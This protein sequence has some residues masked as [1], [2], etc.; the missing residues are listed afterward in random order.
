MWHPLGRKL[1][2]QLGLAMRLYEYEN[3]PVCVM[4]SEHKVLS[5]LTSLMS[6]SSSETREAISTWAQFFWMSLWS[7]WFFWYVKR[8]WFYFT[9]FF[10]HCRCCVYIWEFLPFVVT[11]VNVFNYVWKQVFWMLWIIS[12]AYLLEEFHYWFR[13]A[14]QPMIYVI[15]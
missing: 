14:V 10:V 3:L 6:A 4:S 7:V 2:L 1:S 5:C 12:A 11:I 13:S 8:Y 9:L 15:V